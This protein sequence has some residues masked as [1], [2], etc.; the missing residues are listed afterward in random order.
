LDVTGDVT[1]NGLAIIAGIRPDGHEPA[2]LL[3]FRRTGRIILRGEPDFSRGKDAA[4]NHFPIRLTL[5][6]PTADQDAISLALWA[7]YV[8]PFQDGQARRFFQLAGVDIRVVAWLLDGKG[9]LNSVDLSWVTP[10][11]LY[12]YR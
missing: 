11:G 10:R 6:N 7:R 12:P 4:M 3:E 8:A 9:L 1:A 5:K 2:I